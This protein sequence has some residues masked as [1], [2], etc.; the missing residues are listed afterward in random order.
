VWSLLPEPPDFLALMP[1]YKP[2]ETSGGLPTTVHSL[3]GNSDVQLL[4]VQTDNPVRY[5]L[6]FNLTYK[7]KNFRFETKLTYKQQTK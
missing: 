7:A 4:D 1:V 5:G 3:T 2:R 6:S